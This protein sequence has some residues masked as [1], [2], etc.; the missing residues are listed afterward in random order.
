MT[1]ESK[2]TEQATETNQVDAAGAIGQGRGFLA[3]AAEPAE[4][5]GVAA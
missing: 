2:V 3:K 1:I 5:M 4:Q